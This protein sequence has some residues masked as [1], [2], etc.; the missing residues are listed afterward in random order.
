MQSKSS[1]D[2]LRTLNLPNAK[3]INHRG[4]L[5]GPTIYHTSY[6]HR[7]RPR[8]QHGLLSD[9]NRQPPHKQVRPPSCPR[10]RRLWARLRLQLD[11]QL[12]CSLFP[13]LVLEPRLHLE[14]RDV[15]PCK[16]R[17]QT[18]VAARPGHHD[19][20]HCPS[21]S[22]QHA[23]TSSCD[24]EPLDHGDVGGYYCDLDPIGE[25]DAVIGG[26]ARSGLKMCVLYYRRPTPL[27]SGCERGRLLFGTQEDVAGPKG[28][29]YE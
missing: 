28:I 1:F 26:R 17:A 23:A 25:E 18:E 20:A 8:D 14:R 6:A 13:G 9:P 21:I 5:P 11:L 4:T 19:A 16:A 10:A 22:V 15:A 24:G 12:Q 3:L 27:R 2:H 29:A 7:A